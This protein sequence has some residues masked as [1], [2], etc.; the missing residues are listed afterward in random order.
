MSGSATSRRATPAAPRL[1]G[2]TPDPAAPRRVR[3]RVAGQS[4]LLLAVAGALLVCLAWAIASP[5]FAYPDEGAHVTRAAAVVD[6]Q[7]VA[8]DKPVSKEGWPIIRAPNSLAQSIYRA[9]CL[10]SGYGHPNVAGSCAKPRPPYRRMTEV[11]NAAGRYE[12][13]YYGVVGGPL[14]W[15]PTSN[16]VYA[17]RV[18]NAVVCV[19]LLAVALFAAGLG[20]RRRPWGPL[21]LLTGLTPYV[22]YMGGGINPSAWEI[23]AA[24]ATW[25]GV[26]RLCAD[27]V[28]RKG[29]VAATTLAAAVLAVSRPLGPLWLVLIAGVAV[30]ATPWA[31]L[32]TLV[33][34]RVIQAAIAVAGATCVASLMWTVTQ[35]N[36]S[37][38]S[39]PLRHPL[40]FGD[41]FAQSFDRLPHRLEELVAVF[42]WL[43]VPV[44]WITVAVWIALTALLVGAALRWGAG[45]ARWTLG[46]LAVVTVLVPALVEA[47]MATRIG[48]VWQGRY[49]LPL[50]VGLPLLAGQLLDSRPSRLLPPRWSLPLAAGLAGIAQLAAF[51]W[52]LRRYEHGV[53]GSLNPFTG[54]WQPPGGPT[55]SIALFA[56]G[57]AA[58]CAGIVLGRNSAESQVSPVMPSWAGTGS[59]RRP[60]A[61]QADARTD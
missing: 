28:A 18:V 22:L 29:L 9:R 39:S 32:R 53:P 44:P 8:P 25:A 10:W 6:G 24:V 31:K 42:G 38:D 51:V 46:G 11:K 12:P 15:A 23:C 54:A 34:A 41:A 1:D 19:L 43:D 16:G 47:H 45:R 13:G 33:H 17:A 59:N 52:A 21:G 57:I 49:T 27:G 4:A 48:M 30:A 40:P 7:V 2:V 20:S 56:G 3:D 26:L 14:R 58:L 55:L 35:T 37:F 36:A 50:A 5:V 61:F 60:S